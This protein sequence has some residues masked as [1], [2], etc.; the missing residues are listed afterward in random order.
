M[1]QTSGDLWLRL[2]RPLLDPETRFAWAEPVFRRLRLRVG[3]REQPLEELFARVLYNDAERGVLAVGFSES[4]AERSGCDALVKV[5]RGAK[6][7]RLEVALL[8][9]APK[10]LALEDRVIAGYAGAGEGSAGDL[11]GPFA[12]VAVLHL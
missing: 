6:G 7:V 5:E 3:G 11:Q 12:S 4:Q 2:R 8:G 10:E 1:T 9:K